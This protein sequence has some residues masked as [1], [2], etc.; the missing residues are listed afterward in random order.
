MHSTI[1][2][3]QTNS[4][5]TAS[6]QHHRRSNGVREGQTSRQNGGQ[7]V[8]DGPED[9]HEGHESSCHIQY[10]LQVK[11]PNFSHLDMVTVKKSTKTCLSTVPGISLRRL[12]K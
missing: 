6:N 1:P 8:T 4:V 2:T 10:K 7:M 5:K 9:V 11:L 3:A 12:L